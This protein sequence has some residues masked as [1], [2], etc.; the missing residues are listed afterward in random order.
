MKSIGWAFHFW[1]IR[2]LS[3]GRED[4]TSFGFCAAS[5]CQKGGAMNVMIGRTYKCHPL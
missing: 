1:Y 2:Y 3:V 5:S 4:A